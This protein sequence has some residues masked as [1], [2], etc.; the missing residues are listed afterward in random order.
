M[1]LSETA[2]IVGTLINRSEIKGDCWIWFGGKT[3]TG[4]GAL[5][6]DGKTKLAHRLS[7]EIFSGKNLGKLFVCHSCDTPSCINPNHLWAG[8]QS[9]NQKDCYKKGRS[10]FTGKTGDKHLRAKLSFAKADEIRS[11]Y[12]SGTYDQY[13]LASRFDVHRNVISAIVNRRAWA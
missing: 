2:R 9:D 6:S 10:P 8:T 3:G 1:Q 4:Y 5:Q 12:A 11:L 7:Y 13:Q